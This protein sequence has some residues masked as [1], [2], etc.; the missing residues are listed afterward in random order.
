MHRMR[1]LHVVGDLLRHPPLRSRGLERQ[2]ALDL[3]ARPPGHL[4]IDTGGSPRFL[5]F[6][7]QPA[8]HPEE[9][10]EYQPRL[11]WRAKVVQQLQSSVRGRGMRL[12]NRIRK[13]RKFVALEN[14]GR[15]WVV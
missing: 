2:H 15:K 5:F 10:V 12:S 9:L 11:S 7:I 3:L 13:G 14:R 8:L 6:R 1:L 4:K